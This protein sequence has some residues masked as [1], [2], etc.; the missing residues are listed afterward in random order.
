MNRTKNYTTA[1][2]VLVFID[3]FFA[4]AT[5]T[6][7]ILS[8]ARTPLAAAGAVLTVRTAPP[9]RGT[10]WSVF[11]FSTP[12]ADLFAMTSQFTPSTLVKREHTPTH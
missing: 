9:Q 7:H 8:A 2:R 5:A 11:F 6:T 3:G 4:V 1:V 10:P 12:T